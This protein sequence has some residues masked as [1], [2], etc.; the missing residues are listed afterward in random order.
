MGKTVTWTGWWT[1]GIWAASTQPPATRSAQTAENLDALE[2][3]PLSSV[4]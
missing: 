1:A 2:P 4:L 3:L